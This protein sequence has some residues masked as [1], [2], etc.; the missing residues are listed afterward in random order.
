M[1][2]ITASSAFNAAAGSIDVA[3][4]LGRFKV[5]Y[6]NSIREDPQSKTPWL[7]RA[8]HCIGKAILADKAEAASRHYEQQQ[9]QQLQQL[10]QQQ[11]Q[12]EGQGP[13]IGDAN[14]RRR[15]S[16]VRAVALFQKFKDYN[17]GGD[18]YL[19]YEDFVCGIKRLNIDE[20]ELG[21]ALTD[22]HLFRVA[23]AIDLTGSKRINY[24]EFL[25]AF[26]VVD[27]SSNN[28]LAEEVNK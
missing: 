22:A 17:E 26:H 28:N 8:F 4:F 23:E 20:E 15:S 18:G 10:Q 13:L 2:L 9:L 6:S 16:A 21:F 19:S 25:Q 1:R 14:S 27:S 24:L 3:E 5:V 12:Q 11:Q 7:R